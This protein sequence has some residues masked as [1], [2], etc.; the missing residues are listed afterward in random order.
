MA[1]SSGLTAS[2]CLWGT[3]QHVF[4]LVFDA[5][6]AVGS[7]EL[8]VDGI[9]YGSVTIRDPQVDL[10]DAAFFQVF[11]QILPNSLVLTLA[12]TEG[13]NIAFACFI[14][15]DR[16][17]NRH[18]AARSIVNDTEICPVGENIQVTK[19]QRALLPT[20]K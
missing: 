16:R 19:L 5:A 4:H 6:L 14:N 1:R 13:Q 8:L 7:R 17:Q 18:F 3:A 11:K 20:G 9:G 15:T 2:C 12:D 10:N